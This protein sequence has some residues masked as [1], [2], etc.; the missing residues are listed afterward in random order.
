MVWDTGLK[1]TRDFNFR[2]LRWHLLLSYL[3]VMAAILFLFAIG[4]YLFFSYSFYQQLDEKLR[5]LA[6]SAAPSLSEVEKR[7]NEYLDQ[8]SV[9][10]W[11]D[12]FNRDQ[13]SL[14]WFNAKGELLAKRGEL[15]LYF[16]PKPGVSKIRLSNHPFAIHTYTISVFTNSSNK[17]TILKGFIRASQSTESIKVSQKQLLLWLGIGGSLA[18]GLAGI[19]G[20]WLTQKA[21]K[22]IEQSYKQ[23]KQFTADA[24]HELRSPLTAIKTSVDVMLT[25]L[26]RI[27]PKDLKKLSAIS[28]ATVQMNH[29]V[30]DLLFLARTDVSASK[31][32]HEWLP[33]KL[34]ELLQ[35]VIDLIAPSAQ[36]KQIRFISH[37]SIP[38]MIHGD[39]NCLCRLLSNLLENAIQYTSTGGKITVFLKK[40][41][42]FAV[43]TI[44]DTGIGIAEEHLPF[45]FD[46][47]WRADKARSHREGG[48]GLGLSIAQAVALQHGGKITVA[49]KLGVGSCFFVHLPRISSTITGA[50]FPKNSDFN[51]LT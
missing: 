19:G 49:S 25:H 46:R 23:L 51:S 29:L 32:S 33:I 9:F 31:L 26:E 15:V 39:R 7:G 48:T 18:L 34:H 4:V 35:D 24:S 11:R 16:P 5:A 30:D 43:I 27:H 38:L 37:V 13:Q 40:Q 17:K 42:R 22:P 6:Q 14:E 21:L 36:A 3:T 41:N 12:L 10:P 28:S 20:L 45:I 1:K 44:K 8:M 50:N 47:F 2:Y